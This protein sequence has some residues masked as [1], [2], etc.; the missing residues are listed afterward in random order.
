MLSISK[1]IIYIYTKGFNTGFRSNGGIGTDLEFNIFSK[2]WKSY[3][4]L[5]YIGFCFHTIVLNQR[6]DIT[7]SCFRLD[8]ALSTNGAGVDRELSSV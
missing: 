6:M 2:A 8:K 3:V 5:K 7:Q 4:K 1:A